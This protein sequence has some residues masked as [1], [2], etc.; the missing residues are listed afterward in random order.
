MSYAGTPMVLPGGEV[1]PA[2]LTEDSDPVILIS[3][4]GTTWR[5]PSGSNVGFNQERGLSI[6][7]IKGLKGNVKETAGFDDWQISIT[8][9]LTAASFQIGVPVVAPS[10]IQQIKSLVAIWKLEH[11]LTLNNLKMNAVGINSV[12]LQSIDFGDPASEW[13]QPVSITCVSDEALDLD[14]VQLDSKAASVG[15]MLA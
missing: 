11:E 15:S 1:P 6:T 9:I 8:S 13:Q 3:R 10:I 2:F 14:Q 5:F 7:K 12:I 4:E